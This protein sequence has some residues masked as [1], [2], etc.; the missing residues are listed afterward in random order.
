MATI[1]CRI[2]KPIKSL[3]HIFREMLTRLQKYALV[4]FIVLMSADLA[5]SSY[6][7]L[8]FPAFTEAN[9]L[10]SRFVDYPFRF[11]A[12]VGIT[13]LLVITGIIGATIW[14]NQR[15][16]A[17]SPWHGGDLLCSTAAFG[18]GTMMLVL[19]AG[20]LFVI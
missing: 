17:G 20:N 1:K 6:G 7:V 19:V 15:E 14:F 16:K 5:I 9:I 8:F 12:V 2:R 13:K 4:A 11:I 18:M 3:S 10:F